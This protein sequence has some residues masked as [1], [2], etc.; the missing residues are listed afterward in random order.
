M[1]GKH[2]LDEKQAA[3][4]QIVFLDVIIAFLKWC[5]MEREVDLPPCFIPA[6]AAGETKAWGSL[7]HPLKELKIILGLRTIS[8]SAA[9]AQQLGGGGGRAGS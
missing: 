3:P 5:L 4:F 8:C 7:R 1:A 6:C 9:S 2:K